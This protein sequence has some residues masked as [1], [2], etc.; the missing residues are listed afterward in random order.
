MKTHR[1]ST[2]GEYKY[3]N[4]SD[5]LAAKEIQIQIM[6]R[7]HFFIHKTG[8]VSN[9][10]NAQFQEHLWNSHVRE[11]LAPPVWKAVW[12]YVLTF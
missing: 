6:I 8:K 11:K 5:S 1:K 12:Q 2:N 9:I 3:E 7:H 10:D 4:I